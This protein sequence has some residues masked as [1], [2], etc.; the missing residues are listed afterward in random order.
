MLLRP[1]AQTL[2]LASSG[3]VL[4]VA[5]C[6][7]ESSPTSVAGAGDGAD[8]ATDS[9]S[10]DASEDQFDAS[11]DTSQDEGDADPMA[12]PPELAQPCTS[13]TAAAAPIPPGFPDG[14][15]RLPG[16]PADVNV[17]EIPPPT[18]PLVWNACGTGCRELEPTWGAPQ[19]GPL[20]RSSSGGQANA[21]PWLALRQR[22]SDD[23]VRLWVGPADAQARW[24]FIEADVSASDRAGFVAPHSVF[25]D[26]LLPA[27]FN[28]EKFAAL[29]ALRFDSGPTC[30]VT[31]QNSAFVNFATMASV[32]S[33]R[34][35]VSGY[36]P[37]LS[38]AWPPTPGAEDLKRIVATTGEAGSD[39]LV[40]GDRLIWG[41][42]VAPHYRLWTWRPGEEPHLLLG[43]IGDDSASVSTD[44]TQ[45]VWLQARGYYE[46]EGI[47][48]WQTV[49]LRSAP[50]PTSD[51][52]ISGTVLRTLPTS[53][54]YGGVH[55]ASGFL[56]DYGY[57]SVDDSLGYYY[58]MRVSDGETWKFPRRGAQQPWSG[59]AFFTGTEIGL[60]EGVWGHP[61]WAATVVRYDI[62]ALGPGEM[63]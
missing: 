18:E 44:G 22:L 13:A 6:C 16:L 42:Y 23:R 56:A 36:G 21:V 46:T 5:G 8:A 15:K 52:P 37:I 33:Q 30:V 50:L 54:V 47:S 14:A 35:A 41:G 59:M 31:S 1:I 62:T 26:G 60:F 17:F 11:G 57:D 58:V 63:P 3:A 40:V 10:A 61:E 49:E 53:Y 29:L 55:F 38:G 39:V 43:D 2:M 48:H 28:T 51:Q 24:A 12:V 27:V 7:C 4:A 45:L 19:G 34:W 9:P 32:S 20:W 25:A